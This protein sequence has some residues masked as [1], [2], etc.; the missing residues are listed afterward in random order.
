[1]HQRRPPFIYP[2]K[3][4]SIAIF[5]QRAFLQ[6]LS[7]SCP[8]N[9]NCVVVPYPTRLADSSIHSPF[10]PQEEA[11]NPLLFSGEIYVVISPFRLTSH[12]RCSKKVV[13][14]HARPKEF[15]KSQTLIPLLKGDTWP[16]IDQV[17]RSR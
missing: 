17:P 7:F 3:K 11:L 15:L 16:C 12:A 13:R 1:M 6:H 10:L 5:L 2:Q 4:I 9:E 14:S 8:N